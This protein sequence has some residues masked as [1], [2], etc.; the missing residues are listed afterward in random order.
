MSTFVTEHAE[1]QPIPTPPDFPVRWDRP[2][3]ARY[4]WT[5]DR[6]HFPDVTTPLDAAIMGDIHDQSFNV[7]LE[8]LGMPVRMHFMVANGYV[9]TAM[10]PV[11]SSPEEMEAAEHQV[12]ERLGPALGSLG[13]RWQNEQLPAI[14]RHLAWWR[15]LD[16]RG[17]DEP[18]LLGY[19]DETWSRMLRCWEIHSEVALPMLMS[20]GLFDTATSSVAMA[21]SRRTACC[22]GSTTSRWKRAVPCGGSVAKRWPTRTCDACCRRSRRTRCS[23]H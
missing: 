3:D 13:G 6:M 20:M 23:R 9:Y 4:F 16:L 17:A 2:E 21:R 1:P 7:P 5:P 18:T 10:A 22:K 8:A 19:F 14:K 11:V 12:Q 15:S